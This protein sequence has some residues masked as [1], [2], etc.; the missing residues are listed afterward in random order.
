MICIF[1]PT[2]TVGGAERVVSILANQW[3]KRERVTIV[4]YFEAP[5]FFQISPAVVVI[6]LGF[7]ANRGDFF[8]CIDVLLAARS[9]RKTMKRIRPSFVLSFMNKYN[10]FCLAALRGTRI[11]VIVS[12]RGS[13]SEKLPWIRVV[14]RDRLYPY[15]AGLICQTEAGRRFME[16]RG[17]SRCVTVIPNPVSRVVEPN[18]RRPE[19]IVLGVG[20]LIEGKGF[21]HLLEAFA[22]LQV[23]GW[24]LVLCGDGPERDALKQK[25]AA[26]GIAD[27]V[28]FAGVVCDLRPYFQRAGIFAF[29][30]MHEGYPNA[31]AEALVSGLP[32][33]SYDCPTGPSELIV[34]GETGLLVRV[35]DRD[36]LARA[37]DR[38]AANPVFAEQLGAAALGRAQELEP[39]RVAA[40]YLDFCVRAASLARAQ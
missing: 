31:L 20:R 19:K 33:V 21:D 34:D 4:T 6:N 37:I 23:L 7:K 5:T 1:I 8:R 2:L 14:A 9:F 11:P 29:S 13:P 26:L 39:S 15:A 38:L 10:A 22:A 18:E 32:C 17:T 28:E 3:A 16:S 36:E 27:R 24:R 40:A 25:A 12:E 30:S 35:G